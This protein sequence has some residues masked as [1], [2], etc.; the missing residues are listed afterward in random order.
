MGYRAW[1]EPLARTGFVAKGVVY[2]LLGG[3]ALQFALG[4]GGRITDS[5]GAVVSLLQEPYGR[6]TIGALAVGLALYA[7]WRC[8]EAFG[9]ANRKGTNLQGL[10]AR[11]GYF[12]SACVYGT[13][14]FD[15]ARLA[16]SPARASSGNERELPPLLFE[17]AAGEW[18]VM[19][20]AVA[21]VVYGIVQGWR[22]FSRRLSDRL[23]LGRLSSQAR[24]WV[25]RV[26]RFGIGA[27][28]VV[29]TLM[30]VIMF[31]RSASLRAAA[32]TDTAESL[33][34]LSTLPTGG[35]I[36]AGVA[37]GLMAYGVYQFVHARYRA[38]TPP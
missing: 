4:G 9:D 36:L 2:L 6:L 7:G 29:L 10:G 26:S 31:R 16:G 38:I 22:A 13:L 15:A 32:D 1:M 18:A 37:A 30:G 25:M 8:L 19:A 14:A 3:L 24:P 21:L 20:V 27:R 33:R 11:A 12:L 35:W 34:L 5:R 17:S 23:N 28:A